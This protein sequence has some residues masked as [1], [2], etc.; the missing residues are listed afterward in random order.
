MEKRR[1]TWPFVGFRE[2][3]DRVLARDRGEIRLLMQG[4]DRARI[5]VVGEG[6][7]PW[8]V[9]EGDLTPGSWDGRDDLEQDRYEIAEGL[10]VRLRA[11]IRNQVRDVL[12]EEGLIP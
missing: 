7:D 1:D 9:P 2:D 6:Q 5:Y 11:F 10:K 12:R 8:T 4:I 3:G